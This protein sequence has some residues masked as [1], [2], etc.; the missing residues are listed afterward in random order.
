LREIPHLQ[1]RESFI[2]ALN[3]LR[4]Y[5]ASPAAP[6]GLI[7]WLEHKDNNPWIFFCV[8]AGLTWMPRIIWS[9]TSFTANAA[10]SAHALSQ[11][12]GTC[13]TLVGAIQ[14]SQ[15]IDEQFFVVQRSIRD[16]G[17]PRGYGNRSGSGR[18]KKNM[19]RNEK[20]AKKRREKERERNGEED[21][22]NE[23]EELDSNFLQ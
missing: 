16:S 12:Y 8:C 7:T 19:V 17:I 4:T 22:Q 1:T 20:R 15:K 13:M 21:S 23:N 9:N 11:R 18:A 14:Q 2:E 6:D 3:R 10:E 5:A